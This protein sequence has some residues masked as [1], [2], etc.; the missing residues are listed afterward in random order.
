M[1]KNTKKNCCVGRWGRFLIENVLH[2]EIFRNYSGIILDVNTQCLKGDLTFLLSS[3]RI[4]EISG[5][6]IGPSI[7]VSTRLKHFYIQLYWLPKY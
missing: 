1:Q 7:H 6:S 3:E 4:L 5:H 2:R